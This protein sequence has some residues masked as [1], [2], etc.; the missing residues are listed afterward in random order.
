[1][2]G[3]LHHDD[4]FVLFAGN[5]GRFVPDRQGHNIVES[6]FFEL[7]ASGSALPLFNGMSSYLY[8]TVFS[9]ATSLA[10]TAVPGGFGSPAECCPLVSGR[11]LPASKPQITLRGQFDRKVL[12]DDGTPSE[13]FVINEEFIATLDYLVAASL[14]ASITEAR[15]QGP[16]TVLPP[17]RQL[18]QALRRERRV[19]ILEGRSV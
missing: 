1:M 14:W 6:P 19:A 7:A 15:V 12:N 4:E 10:A 11:V 5:F 8:I 16:S 18:L 2:I 13:R 9:K 17:T 3:H